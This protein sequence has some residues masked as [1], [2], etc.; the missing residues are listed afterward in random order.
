MTLVP[1]GDVTAQNLKSKQALSETDFLLFNDV[2]Y[3]VWTLNQDFSLTKKSFVKIDNIAAIEDVTYNSAL[4]L[5][6]AVS[7]G[8][9]ANV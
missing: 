4:N 3:G 5:Y 8:S 9:G 2:G 1:V 7:F 6:T